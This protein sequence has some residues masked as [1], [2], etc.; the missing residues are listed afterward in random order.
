MART[1]WNPRPGD[2]ASPAPA[3]EDEPSGLRDEPSGLRDPTRRTSVA[4]FYEGG[5]DGNRRLTVQT[6]V[7]L[8][9]V[10][11]VLGVTIVRIGQLLWLHLFIGLLLLGPV[12]LKLAS[13]GYRFVRYYTHEPRYRRKG[14]PPMYLRLAAPVLVLSTA[15]V[16]ATGVALLLL[17]PSSRDPLLLLHKASFFVWLAVMALHVLSHLPE[18]AS[19]FASNRVVRASLLAP[20]GYGNG[21]RR[22]ASTRSAHEQRIAGGAGRELS[23]VL[24]CAVGLLMA[25]A[26]TSRYGA[27]IDYRRVSHDHRAHEIGALAGRRG[28]AVARS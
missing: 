1:E 15:I 23:L 10:F 13:T 20:A 24:A 5:T 2:P 28:D 8:V 19:E 12:A 3:P 16:F 6:G 7:L 17:G 27:W 11:A 25:L 26:L 9:V 18:V 14:P 22:E 21:A 4:R